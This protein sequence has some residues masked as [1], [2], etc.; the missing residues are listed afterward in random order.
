MSQVWIVMREVKLAYL[1]CVRGAGE[2]G[3]GLH[4]MSVDLI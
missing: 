1:G 4:V 3:G 2:G